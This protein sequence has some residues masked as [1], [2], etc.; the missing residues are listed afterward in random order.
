MKQSSIQKTLDGLSAST[1][2]FW[3]TVDAAFSRPNKILVAFG[4]CPFQAQDHVS[5]V[6]VNVPS[7]SAVDHGT[8]FPLQ[9]NQQRLYNCVK[10]CCFT[11]TDIFYCNFNGR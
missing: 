5:G 6:M 11:E 7:S 2:L 4:D 1:P 9:S 3:L 8:Q 10:N